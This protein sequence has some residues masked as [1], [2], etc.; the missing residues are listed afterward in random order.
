MANQDAV[1]I[2]KE[3]LDVVM[4]DFPKEISID[5]DGKNNLT[6]TLH[7]EATGIINNQSGQVTNMQDNNACFEGWVLAIRAAN[8]NLNIKLCVSGLDEE[9]RS[10]SKSMNQDDDFAEKTTIVENE[11]WIDKLVL[12]K[13]SMNELT[14]CLFHKLFWNISDKNRCHFGRFLYRVLRFSEQYG[15]VKGS[16]WFELD[17]VLECLCKCFDRYL[18]NNLFLNTIPRCE[19]KRISSIAE[20]DDKSKSSKEYFVEQQMWDGKLKLYVNDAE[21]IGRQF[22]VSLF[23]GFVSKGTRIFSG[24]FL[25]LWSL[26]SVDGDELTIY[27]LKT[28]N[29]MVGALTEIFFYANFMYDLCVKKIFDI[30]SPT[31]KNYRNYDYIYLFAKRNVTR[32]TKKVKGIILFDDTNLHPLLA[33]SNI[34]EIMNKNRTKSKLYYVKPV[35]YNISAGCIVK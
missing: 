17:A 15:K 25:D 11:K 8:E 27:E 23:E 7:L 4:K 12:G 6:M 21:C 9:L 22:P 10:L 30:S 14:D 32:V 1:K 13:L 18:K 2:L 26:N 31:D 35:K 3:E 29:Q 20:Y 16:G 33:M 34:I 19:P 24:G 28:K 5:F